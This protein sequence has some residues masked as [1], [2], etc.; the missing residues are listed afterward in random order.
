MVTRPQFIG[1][2]WNATGSDFQRFQ[3]RINRGSVRWIVRPVGQGKAALRAAGIVVIFIITAS[4]SEERF[5]ISPGVDMFCVGLLVFEGAAVQVALH[6]VQGCDDRRQQFAAPDT[7]LVAWA[8]VPAAHEDA[9]VL[10]VARADLQPHRDAFFDVLPGLVT[11]AQVAVVKPDLKARCAV[12]RYEIKSSE[13]QVAQV[14]PQA[15]AIFH[16]GRTFIVVTEN[17]VD[18]DMFGG[19]ARR[20]DQAVVVA[21]SHDQAANEAR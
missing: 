8:L 17:W 9:V 13:L 18:H 3:F 19:E 12:A 21:V 2:Q 14:T 7:F 11:T 1:I 10:N 6:F 5:K 20:Q 4:L 16:D 15:V